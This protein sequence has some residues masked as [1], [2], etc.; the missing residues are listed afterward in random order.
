M[1]RD[2][3]STRDYGTHTVPATHWDEYGPC[4]CA[5]QPGCPCLDRRIKYLPPREMW[6][7]H[8]GRQNYAVPQEVR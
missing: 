8:P 7:A 5:A 3:Q 1:S 4:G 6:T 2:G